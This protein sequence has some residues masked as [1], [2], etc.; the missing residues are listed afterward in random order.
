MKTKKELE[1]I[2]KGC[3]NHRRVE[4]LLLL[5]EEP[6]LTLDQIASSLDIDFRVASEHIRRMG[7]GGLVIKRYQG[8]HVHH[9]L[10][11]RAK[12]ILTF[13]GKLE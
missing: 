6:E 3:A 8:R 11:R 7:A 1:R 4:I 5:G 13:L 10:T 2:L 12:N 9:A